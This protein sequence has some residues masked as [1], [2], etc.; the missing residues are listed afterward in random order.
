MQLLLRKRN[1]TK[2]TQNIFSFSIWRICSSWSAV[3]CKLCFNVI[4]L[5]CKTFSIT[6]VPNT[7]RHTHIHQALWAMHTHSLRH[8]HTFIILWM[9]G[10]YSHLILELYSLFE[11]LSAICQ[12]FHAAT[13]RSN[14]HEKVRKAFATPPS[15]VPLSYTVSKRCESVKCWRGSQGNTSID[16]NVSIYTYTYI[17]F[18]IHVFIYIPIYIYISCVLFVLQFCSIILMQQMCWLLRHVQ[19]TW[20]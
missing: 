11:L 4:L 5:S 7:L 14:W 12:H 17:Q 19:V 2:R 6:Q 9:S 15:Y 13:R 3:T 20:L 8:S 18:K 16:E 1:E 10:T